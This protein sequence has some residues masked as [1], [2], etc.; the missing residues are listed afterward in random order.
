MK[1]VDFDMSIFYPVPLEN[2]FT[3]CI[4]ALTLLGCPGTV[5]SLTNSSTTYFLI[6]HL[7]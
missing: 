4:L 1:A 7:Q 2:D 3:V 5:I 6:F